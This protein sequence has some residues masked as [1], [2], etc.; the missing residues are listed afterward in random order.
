MVDCLSYFGG[1]LQRKLVAGT[2]DS[3]AVS[4]EIGRRCVGLCNPLVNEGFDFLCL[5]VLVI[6]CT[7]RLLDKANLVSLN[8]S[9]VAAVDI[10]HG[11]DGIHQRVILS[12][13]CGLAGKLL[14]DCLLKLFSIGRVQPRRSQDGFQ[15]SNVLLV[16]PML[17]FELLND[18]GQHFVFFRC[19]NLQLPICFLQNLNIVF[20][21]VDNAIDKPLLGSQSKVVILFVLDDGISQVIKLAT[22]GSFFFDV[23]SHC[24]LYCVGSLRLC[25][26]LDF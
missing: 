7:L 20:I 16:L 24:L 3:G 21:L 1:H 10:R 11:F 6:K 14:A 12:L 17:F 13:D 25:L 15:L 23:T 2:S 26:E 18:S 4:A 8:T 9:P 5:K 22:K 19:K